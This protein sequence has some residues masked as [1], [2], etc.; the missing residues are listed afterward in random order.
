MALKRTRMTYSD[1]SRGSIDGQQGLE[2]AWEVQLERHKWLVR[3]SQ[4]GVWV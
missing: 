2:S 1:G 3:G 4:L